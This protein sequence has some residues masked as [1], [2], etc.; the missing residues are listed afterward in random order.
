[1]AFRE[2]TGLDHV[3][4]WARVLE[5]LLD[6]ILVAVLEWAAMTL[7]KSLAAGYIVGLVASVLNFIVLQKIRGQTV[8]K[9]VMGHH[10]V[11][12]DGQPLSWGI[13]IGRYFAMMLSA[14]ILYIG[15]MMAGWTKHKQ[16]LHDK[17]CGT[18]V[19]RK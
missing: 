17:I 2:D 12:A 3:G 18:Y 1:M 14:L 6:G 13:V 7:S 15:F 4:F 19:I 11:R 10:L 5:Y 9:M 16:G 8:G